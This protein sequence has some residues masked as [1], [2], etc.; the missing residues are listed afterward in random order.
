MNFKAI[1]IAIIGVALCA[2]TSDFELAKEF[3]NFMRNYNRQ[4]SSVEET[5]KRFKIFSDTYRFIE[6]FNKKEGNFK[7]GINHFADLTDEEFS[8]TYLSPRK[9]GNGG[10]I[11]TACWEVHQPITPQ[12]HIDWRNVN[13]VGQVKLQASVYHGGYHA[14]VGAVEGLQAI[15]SGTFIEYSTN[16]AVK[17]AW[18]FT[19][20][21]IDSTYYFISEE[22]ISEGNET[23]DMHCNHPPGKNRYY[24]KGCV[25]VEIGNNDQLLEALAYGP[26]A[27]SVY[28]IFPVFRYYTHGIFDAYTSA[29]PKLDHA[30]LIVGA[31]SE[32]DIPYWIVKNS[33][34]T[35][36][37]MNG[38]MRIKRNVGFEPSIC[39]IAEE[40][41]Y[42]IAHP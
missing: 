39:G 34:G 3:T 7:L 6:E 30:I 31:S 14:A 9:P 37:G 24:I 18:S 12:T 16:E 26:V 29:R 19:D 38:Y 28:T 23:P 21:D 42:P 36:W 10:D 11:I 8:A 17:C 5:L 20:N 41:F 15:K 25:L 27:S 40:S 35:A 2:K 13:A 33:W 32:N 22:G 1:L 4:Y